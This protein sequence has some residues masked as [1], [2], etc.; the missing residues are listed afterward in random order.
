MNTGEPLFLTNQQ[1]EKIHEKSLAEFG[2]AAGVRDQGLIESALASA[3]NAYFYGY[4]D[5]FDIAAAY[6]FHLAEAQAF[7]DGNKRTAMGAALTFLDVNGI[8]SFPT[9]NALY[10]AMIDI[11]NKKLNKQGLAEMFRKESSN[12]Q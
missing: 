12:P 2:G 10:D 3:Q 11:A 7:F 8:S 6:A 9:D 4:G 5:I 1:I